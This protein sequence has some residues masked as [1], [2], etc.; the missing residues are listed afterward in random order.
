MHTPHPWRRAT[1]LA[2]LLALAACHRG[3]DPVIVGAVGPWTLDF[4]RFSR[5]AVQLAVEQVNQGGGIG[6]RPL[7][8]EFRDDSGDA[9]RSAAIASEFVADDRVLAALGPMNSG[10]ALAAARIYDNRLPAV[11]PLAVAPE[12]AGASH[13]FFRTLSNDSVF[14]TSL[15]VYATRIGEPAAVLYD[16]NVYG[17]GGARVFRHSYGG[18]IVG[19]DAI[20]AGDTALEPFVAWY[21]RAGVKLVYVAG[22]GTSGLAFL[23]AAARAGYHPAVVGTDTWQSMVVDSAVAE[24]TYIAARFSVQDPRPEVRA[25]VR[26]F[27]RRFG[28]APDGVAASCYDATMLLAQALREGGQSR[29]AVERWLAGRDES[30]AITGVTGPLGFTADGGPISN[31]FTMLRVRNHKLVDAG[32]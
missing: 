15:G 8:I 2:A 9:E 5:M 16:N 10:A 22:V 13:W 24:G 11:S 25:F 7:Q 12:L 1:A 32:M 18:T 30:H 17:R 20:Q 19:M 29:G 4:L 23:R 26:A 27:E 21:R 31:G 28:T 3:S 14:V 6:G